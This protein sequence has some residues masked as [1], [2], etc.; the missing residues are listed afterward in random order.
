MPTFV[1]V[2][3][4]DELTPGQGKLVEVNRSVSHSSTWMDATMP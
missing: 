4:T 3:R 1:T 2:A